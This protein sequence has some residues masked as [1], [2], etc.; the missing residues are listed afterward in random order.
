MIIL[1]YAN[2]QGYLLSKFFE[3][4]NKLCNNKFIIHYY[5]NYSDIK[6]EKINIFNDL[7]KKCDIFIYQYNK[8]N[9]NIKYDINELKDTCIKI[10]LV[11]WI[12]NGF[13]PDSTYNSYKQIIY[14]NI[15]YNFLEIDWNNTI[16]KLYGIHN[17]FINFYGNYN[18]VKN[19]IDN[20]HIDKNNILNFFNNE[21][22]NLKNIDCNSDI[23][24]YDFFI[25]N[26]KNNELF[27][28]PIHPTNNFFYELFKKILVF[29]KKYDISL[30]IELLDKLDLN[31]LLEYSLISYTKP[32]LPV[33]KNVLN[34]NYN[35]NNLNNNHDTFRIFK[36]YL[37]NITINLNIYEYYFIRLS[38]THFK[39]F[40]DIKNKINIERPINYN[41]YRINYNDLSQL[42][43]NQII[44]HYNKY[45]LIENR[46]DNFIDLNFNWKIYLFHNKDLSFKTM[47][48]CYNHYVKHGKKENR[49]P[50]YNDN[51]FIW[52]TQY[53]EY[54]E[55]IKYTQ[56]I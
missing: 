5:S 34:I 28:C 18:Q 55:Y 32:I 35:N 25:N 37:Q 47:E 21:C 56:N 1:I 16:L 10:R 36:S 2:C 50:S 53:D 7:L 31:N 41:I 22:N 52:N 43:N 15:K 33:V 9:T 38:P 29:L 24:M 8:G 4:Y 17:S 51:N 3:T 44:E 39:I 20:L 19:K 46:N 42:D 23:K 26:Y 12:F 6:I 11:W 40:M 54:N 48:E 13:W 27:H 45:A 30:D 14:N 49:L